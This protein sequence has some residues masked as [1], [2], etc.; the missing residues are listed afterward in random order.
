MQ[1]HTMGDVSIQRVMEKEPPGRASPS[2]LLPDYDPEV[3]ARHMHW[4][5]PNFFNPTTQT[6]ILSFHSWLVRTPHHNILVDTCI[7]NHKERPSFPSMHRQEL[8][9]LDNLRAA[10]LGPEDIDFVMCT[11]LH[12][13]HVGWNTR[14]HDGRWVPTFPNARY[15]FSR[16]ECAHADHR[17]KPES[18]GED[19]DR[20]A[21]TDSVLPILE[22]GMAD[23]VD[24]GV[25]ALN[26]H[27]TIEPAAGHTPGS[28]TFRVRAGGR[29]GLFIGDTIHHPIQV[30]RPDWSSGACWDPDASCVTRRRILAESADRDV[31]FFPAHFGN[32]YTGRVVTNAEGFAFEFD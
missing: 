28:V 15:V 5:A 27:M 17:G 6:L 23:L 22:A 30:Y 2:F 26:D 18:H 32:P 10:G 4:L 3:F 24:D 8:P 31:M 12:A 21:F 11:H 1:T 9:W 16:T 25:H 7:G 29:E 20:R 14:L 19:H 13:D